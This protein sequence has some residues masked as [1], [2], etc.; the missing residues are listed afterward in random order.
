MDAVHVVTYVEVAP[1][2]TPAAL[3]LLR[4]YRG[5]T[6]REDGN[7]RCEVLQRI[8]QPHQLAVVEVWTG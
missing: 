7:L 4:R 5:A 3:A 2:S 8:G 1:P 6:A